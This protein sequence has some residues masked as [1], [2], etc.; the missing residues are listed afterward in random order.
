MVVVTSVHEEPTDSEELLELLEAVDALRALGHDK[1]GHHLV[2]GSVASS[3]RP[4]TLSD[5]AYREAPFSVYKT[6]H[7]ST[8]LV[9]PFLLIVRTRHVVTMVN[10]LS[11]ATMSS[12]GYSEF[13][14]YSQM[15]TALSPTRG[16]AN[17]P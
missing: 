10:A 1:P 3:P 9:Q 16:A 17:L 8:E 5:D 7:P 4:I 6:D 12:A 11:D 13:P 15:H 14:A 2:P